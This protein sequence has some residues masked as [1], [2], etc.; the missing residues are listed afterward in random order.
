MMRSLKRAGYDHPSPI[1][2]GVIPVALDEVDVVGQ[3]QTG[4]GKTAAFVIPILELLE[5]DSKTPSPQA[6]IL[7]PTRELAMQVSDEVEKLSF[8]LTVKCVS[9]YGGMP[10][11][12]QINRL[13]SGCDIVV[14][15]PGRVLDLSGR[16][17]LDLGSLDCVVLDEAD[18]ML[19]IGF[20]P[21][22]EKI[23]RR[24]PRERQTLLLSATMPAPIR[25]LAEKYMSDPKFLDFSPKEIA[26]ETIEQFFY[27]VEPQRK[28]ELLVTLIEQE[29]PRQAIIF[30]RTRRGVEKL[31]QRLRKKFDD[32]GCMHGE[33]SQR[34]RNRVMSA[35]RQERLQIMIATD[36]M[37]RGIDVSSVS[38]IVNFDIPEDCDDYVHRVGR[39]GRMG[40]DGVAYTF[41]APDQGPELTRIEMRI[42]KLLKKLEM[43]GISHDP[44]ALQEPKEVREVPATLSGRG[45]GKKRYRRL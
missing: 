12:R 43:P 6:L 26:V 20:R 5:V 42:D 37:G 25:R 30:C 8:G 32:V 44:N 28:F 18:R 13:K 29:T 10:I 15:T 31:Y 35:F 11:K 45:R 39:T 14:G 36:V 9:V 40:R 41:A 34:E 4:T 1:Q 7:V 27:T 3:A 24:C 19:D 17:V 23:L 38:H 22:I 16:G 21:D 2:S 33:M